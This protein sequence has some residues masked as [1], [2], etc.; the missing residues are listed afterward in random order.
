MFRFCRLAQFTSFL[1]GWHYWKL[2]TNSYL[3]QIAERHM[4]FSFPY[5]ANKVDIVARQRTKS[6]R[7]T[8]KTDTLIQCY[9]IICKIK[10][11]MKLGSFFT[12]PY[13]CL[14]MLWYFKPSNIPHFDSVTYVHWCLSHHCF[15]KCLGTLWAP[16]YVLK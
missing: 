2:H 3:K 12:Q 8:Y 1:S 16:N 4:R 14:H 7:I 10:N 13:H 5:S 9:F 11:I 6:I 15:R